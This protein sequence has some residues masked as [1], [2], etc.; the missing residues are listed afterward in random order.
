[1]LGHPQCAQGSL[2]A[3]GGCP[4]LSVT[5]ARISDLCRQFLRV[6]GR[7]APLVRNDS[8]GAS[9]AQSFWGFSA[10]SLRAYWRPVCASQNHLSLMFRDSC[11]FVVAW[12][13]WLSFVNLHALFHFGGEMGWSSSIITCFFHLGQNW[14]LQKNFQNFLQV[15][16]DSRRF[17]QV[18]AGSRRFSQV[19]AGSRRFSQV[20]AGFRMFSWVLAGAKTS[21]QKRQIA[22]R[23]LLRWF[24]CFGGASA[25]FYTVPRPS[26][27][28]ISPLF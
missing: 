12:E 25:I 13:K 4:C 9:W 27:I 5:L 10:G 15:L 24:A 11:N 18:L 22:S 28:R 2:T 6:A 16:A 23:D 7:P 17:S 1:M 21:H 3:C 14:R 19:L 26:E 20:L 8:W